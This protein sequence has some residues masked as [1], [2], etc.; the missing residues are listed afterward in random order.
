M[1]IFFMFVLYFKYIRHQDSKNLNVYVY[2]LAVFLQIFFFFCI[3]TTINTRISDT[4]IGHKNVTTD[5]KIG[6]KNIDINRF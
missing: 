4:K 1:I 6:R 3:K 5:H 2:I